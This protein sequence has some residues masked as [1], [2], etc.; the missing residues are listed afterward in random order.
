MDFLRSEGLAKHAAAL[1]LGFVV[2]AAGAARMEAQGQGK[3]AA[4]P[5]VTYDNPFEL[6]AGLNYMNFMA[7]PDLPKQMNLGG[8]EVSGTYWVTPKWGAVADFRGDAG[9]TF[10]KPQI[11]FNGRA[12]AVLYTGMVGVQYRLTK[13]QRIATD[14]H[15]YGGISHGDFSETITPAQGSG[16]Y[17]NISKPIEAAGGSVDFNTSKKWAIRLSP[18][19]ILEQF[20]PG[21]REFFSI[22]GGVVYRIGS[23]R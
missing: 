6:Y 18:D 1:L 17:N 10:V 4:A 5:P 15:A 16:L 3:L 21:T 14:L 7:G 22:S 11:Y 2:L 19:L 20:G 23:R 12:I 13:S 8:V 9:T